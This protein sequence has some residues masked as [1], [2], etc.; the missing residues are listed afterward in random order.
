MYQRKHILLT[1]KL[2]MVKD[3][4]IKYHKKSSHLP[5]LT[6]GFTLNDRPPRLHRALW[7]PHNSPHYELLMRRLL[8]LPRYGYD[9]STKMIPKS[10]TTITVSTKGAR[11]CLLIRQLLIRAGI[12]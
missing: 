7:S 6:P 11:T 9:P 3:Y 4:V 5:A 12:M 2:T 1:I 8:I 10:H